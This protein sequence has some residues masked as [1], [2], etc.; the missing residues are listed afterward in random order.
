MQPSRPCTVHN[1][2]G[3]RW[4]PMYGKYYLTIQNAFFAHCNGFTNFLKTYIFVFIAIAFSRIF[5]YDFVVNLKYQLE[6]SWCMNRTNAVSICAW[7][8]EKSIWEIITNSKKN[9]F[10]NKLDF[11]FSSNL[12]FTA[13]VACKNQ[14]RNQID[15]FW[16]FKL[17]ISKLKKNLVTLD[18]A[19]IKW[20]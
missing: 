12:I 1:V 14:F 4:K 10:Q 7:F 13:C 9:W 8:F 20:R 15:F 6:K 11:L 2:S 3:G 18:I 5:Y 17:E 16:F 19:K